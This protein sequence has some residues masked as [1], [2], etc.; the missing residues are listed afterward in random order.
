MIPNRSPRRLLATAGFSHALALCAA[1]A[2]PWLA[3]GVASVSFGVAL[4]AA[5]PAAAAS[6]SPGAGLFTCLPGRR[7]IV[8]ADSHVH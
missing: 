3:A 1:R 5:A 6:G 4:V 7:T 8:S 2:G